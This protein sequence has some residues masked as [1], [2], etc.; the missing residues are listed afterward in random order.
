MALNKGNLQVS[1]TIEDG[2]IPQIKADEPA[3]LIATPSLRGV[4]GNPELFTTKEQFLLKRGGS[5]PGNND[6]DKLIHMLDG[7][8]KIIHARVNH[9][10]DQADKGT[11]VGT[12]ATITYTVGTDSVVFNATEVG[13]GYNGIEITVD[14]SAAKGTGFVDINVR[15]PESNAFPSA[16]I[17]IGLPENPDTDE[18]DEANTALASYGIEI[19]TITNKIPADG[20]VQTLAGG[21]EDITLITTTDYIGNRSA[22]TGGVYCFND[23]ER[24]NRIFTFQTDA[25]VLNEF[26]KALDRSIDVNGRQDLE[27]EFQTV[28]VENLTQ[29]IAAA[30]ARTA[31]GFDTFYGS[32]FLAVP[33]TIPKPLDRNKNIGI[34]TFT[35][36]LILRYVADKT[37]A[38]Q[39]SPMNEDFGFVTD[40]KSIAWNPREAGNIQDFTNSVYGKGINYIGRV[41]TSEGEKVWKVFGD[42]NL[43]IDQTQIRSRKSAGD[44]IIDLI[45]RLKP[46]DLGMLGKNNDVPEWLKRSNQVEALLEGRYEARLA[47]KAGKN[48]NWR[49]IGDQDVPYDYVEDDLTINTI[50]AIENGIYS[51]RVIIKP[52][53]ITTQVN[54][55]I[56]VTQQTSVLSGE[57]TAQ[58]SEVPA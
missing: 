13:A 27:A 37:R 45:Q 10:T 52:I 17:V 5:L 31:A 28:P 50:A 12:K 25:A 38:M 58:I 19:G 46:I 1:Y 2:G 6:V 8:V 51:Y 48:I 33:T 32:L 11:I 21:V 30:N 36:Y 44:C 42:R 49:I 26:L 35:K 22:S 7:G 24:G 34:D 14:V 56:A 41:T 15:V 57:S 47:I 9:L 53:P 16:P 29:A 4:N 55:A 39:A 23:E 43:L 40:F 20:T 54:G 3:Y 18:L